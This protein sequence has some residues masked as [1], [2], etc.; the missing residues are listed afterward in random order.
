MYRET[1]F[2]GREMQFRATLTKCINNYLKGVN[3]GRNGRFAP[4]LRKIMYPVISDNGL[5]L[6]TLPLTTHPGLSGFYILP[7]AY[8]EFLRRHALEPQIAAIMADSD[9]SVP[10]QVRTCGASI[11]QVIESQN[12]PNSLRAAILPAYWRLFTLPANGKLYVEITSSVLIRDQP[13]PPFAYQHERFAKIFGGSELLWAIKTCWASLWSDQAIIYRHAHQIEPASVSIVV[14]VQRIIPSA[15][16]GMLLNTF[17]LAPAQGESLAHGCERFHPSYSRECWDS[18]HG[19][20]G[21]AL[22]N[23]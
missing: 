21:Y 1:L 12:I 17:S 2:R 3:A 19:T 16:S 13:P 6:T 9:L 23:E 15:R 11:R 20:R 7:G 4:H 18:G 8:R 22:R 10:Q 5:N 14:R